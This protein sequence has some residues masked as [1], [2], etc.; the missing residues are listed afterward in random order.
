MLVLSFCQDVTTQMI[1]SLKIIP[2]KDIE[3]KQI[4]ML[5]TTRFSQFENLSQLCNVL[6]LTNAFRTKTPC[7]TTTSN[8][9]SLTKEKLSHWRNEKIKLTTVLGRRRKNIIDRTAIKEYKDVIVGQQR[10][11][12]HWHV[13]HLISDNNRQSPKM[14]K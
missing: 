7:V 9:I 1:N 5:N 10:K 3:M 4:K 6:T 11:R 2:C 8:P 13:Q 14:R 12:Y